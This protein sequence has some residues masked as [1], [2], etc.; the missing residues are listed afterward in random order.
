MYNC[1][2]KFTKKI[3]QMAQRKHGVT[4]VFYIQQS[5]NNVVWFRGKT[6]DYLFG[7]SHFRTNDINT[8][9][10]E[11]RTAK[12]CHSMLRHSLY[13]MTLDIIDKHTN[14]TYFSKN[15]LTH[16]NVYV[17]ISLMVAVAR[18][19]FSKRVQHDFEMHWN[20]NH[21]Q[22][23]NSRFMHELKDRFM[24]IGKLMN[25]P[26]SLEIKNLWFYEQNLMKR[27]DD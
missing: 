26:N 1:F 4:K 19:G 18:H 21:L 9:H 13:N 7:L 15:I 20:A 8:I 17:L 5:E 3:H 16:K 10:F 27:K 11:R 6:L 25:C 23:G 12:K 14:S 24:R 2:I 22:Y